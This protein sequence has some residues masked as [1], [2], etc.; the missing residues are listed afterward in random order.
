M[1]VGTPT[2]LATVS[3]GTGQT[4]TTASF[5]PTANAIIWVH[6]HGRDT[7]APNIPTISDSAGL[8]WTS[9]FAGQF[10][11]SNRNWI[12]WAVAPASPASMTVTADWGASITTSCGRAFE[13]TG[14]DSTT[15]VVVSSNVSASGSSTTP[16]SGTVPTI[17]A[18]NVQLLF[19]STR[20]GSSVAEG[21]GA[22][23]ELYDID[24]TGLSCHTACYYSTTGDTTPTATIS[25]A[26]WRASALEV[27]AAAAGG[28]GGLLSH[29][30]F[31]LVS[32]D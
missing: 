4:T 3:Q 6:F 22:W 26:P 5:T 1:A 9:V 20:A 14:A 29:Q 2:S 15:P 11:S 28:W 23:T 30:R 7:A 31:R 10:N 12:G 8:T 16:A 18:G 17:T 32:T 25:S 24:G 19:I 21:G 27:A 13:T